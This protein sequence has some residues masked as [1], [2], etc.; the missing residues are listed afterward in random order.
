MPRTTARQK[1]DVRFKK[2]NWK[3]E[4]EKW[5]LRP[6]ARLIVRRARFSE[7]EHHTCMA[8]TTN[9]WRGHHRSGRTK[10]FLLVVLSDNPCRGLR[11]FHSPTFFVYLQSTHQLWELVEEHNGWVQ[12]MMLR[13][14]LCWKNI[15]KLRYCQE[16]KGPP[17]G[18]HLQD[19]WPPKFA[20]V[21]HPESDNYGTSTHTKTKSRSR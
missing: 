12:E 21:L 11:S 18:D 14:S 20:T 17:F 5:F 2:F 16:N 13:I 10:S 19:H 3:R 6:P 8:T 1:K 4:T 15:E 9:C 7:K